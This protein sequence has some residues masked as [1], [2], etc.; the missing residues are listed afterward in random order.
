MVKKSVVETINS[1]SNSKLLTIL[2]DP[3]GIWLFHWIT[4]NIRLYRRL[5]DGLKRLQA[6]FG[7]VLMTLKMRVNIRFKT[8]AYLS[9]DFTARPFESIN[10]WFAFFYKDDGHILRM[11]YEGFR[12]HLVKLPSISIKFEVSRILLLWGRVPNK[13]RFLCFTKH[14][15]D[16]LY[17]PY[18]WS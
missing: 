10:I 3:Q 17:A 7:L 15:S 1:N 13:I 12:Y 9:L 16:N 11:V 2:I 5:W 8:N 4:P 18:H 14:R 6:K